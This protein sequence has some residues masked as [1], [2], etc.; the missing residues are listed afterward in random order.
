VL[1]VRDQHFRILGKLHTLVKLCGQMYGQGLSRMKVAHTRPRSETQKRARGSHARSAT[2]V[3]T[4][5]IHDVVRRQCVVPARH[6]VQERHDVV[7]LVLHGSIHRCT[8]RERKRM[9]CRSHARQNVTAG[10]PM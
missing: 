8:L 7:R 3:K 4:H 6:V 9:R 10:C 2:P 5:H 1:A